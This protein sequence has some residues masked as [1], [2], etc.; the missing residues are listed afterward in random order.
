MN[1]VFVG[2]KKFERFKIIQMI[3]NM[4]FFEY[5]FSYFNLSISC[6]PFYGDFKKDNCRGENAKVR[7]KTFNFHFHFQFY[8]LQGKFTTLSQYLKLFD[9]RVQY[10][11]HKFL[12]CYL[13][14]KLFKLFYIFQQKGLRQYSSILYKIP[15]GSNLFMQMP[16]D[17]KTWKI[18]AA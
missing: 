10:V 14:S 12:Y 11:F 5:L 18:E 9:K 6:N 3:G 15:P 16:K 8:L 1:Y 4:I 2:Q 17:L 13:T 7:L